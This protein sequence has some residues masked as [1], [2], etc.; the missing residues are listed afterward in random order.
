MKQITLTISVDD[1]NCHCPECMAT[2]E[3]DENE[4]EISLGQCADCGTELVLAPD[5]AGISWG[6]VQ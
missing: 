2:F 1:E 4:L 6:R 5:A 3:V